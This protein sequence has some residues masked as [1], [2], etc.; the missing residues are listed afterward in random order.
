MKHDTAVLVLNNA[1][2]GVAEPV[3]KKLTEAGLRVVKFQI[4][5]DKSL[6]TRHETLNGRD[7]LVVPMVMLTEGVHEGSN[8]PMLYPAFELGRTPGV[9][10]TKPIT[11]G[12][13]TGTAADP[14]VLN[15]RGLGICLNT[16]FDGR[17]KSEA[18]LDIEKTNKVV[19]S[20]ITRINNGEV[21]EVSTGLWTE[22]EETEGTWNGEPYKAIARNYKPD[23]LAILTDTVG[24]CSVADGAGLARNEASHDTKRK[25][26]YLAMADCKEHEYSYVEDVFDKFFVYSQRGKMFKQNYSATD[27]EATLTGE[28][29][30]VRRV[31]QYRSV[32]GAVV[33]NVERDNNM[34][35]A[36]LI[37]LIIANSAGA[38]TEDDK[39]FLDKKTEAQLEVIKNNL[40]TKKPEEPKAKPEETTQNAA[41]KAPTLVA[42]TETRPPEGKKITLDDLP[43]ELRKVVINAQNVENR[44]KE[45]AIKVIVANKGNTMKAEELGK[46]DLEILQNMARCAAVAEKTDNGIIPINYAALGGEAATPQ[47]THNEV[48]LPDPV[49]DFSKK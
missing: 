1:P 3:A 22:N 29:T 8:G 45:A 37:A 48:A 7:H 11:L 27:T 35:K 16:K 19:K 49:I 12:H 26:L 30:E 9:W 20:I 28:P 38:F 43:P 33:A 42:N 23:H 14:V 25:L 47:A 21:I 18:W 40:Q 17:L 36:A 6:K 46:M 10:D 41:P 39:G 15:S 32:D 5:K 2:A 34:N 24:A 31:V 44:A 4:N 13:P